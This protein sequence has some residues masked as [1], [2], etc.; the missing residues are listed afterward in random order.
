MKRRLSTLAATLLIALLGLSAA[1][2]LAAT[3]SGSINC[4]AGGGKVGVRAEQQRLGALSAT[5]NGSTLFSVNGY[6]HYSKTS[7]VYS[8][9][10]SASSNTLLYSGTY[11][12]CQGGIG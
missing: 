5:V 4:S 2:A 3:E 11:A 12:W 10:W 6:Y 9:N 1:P 7:L 8:G